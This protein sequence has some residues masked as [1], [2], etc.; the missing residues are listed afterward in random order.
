MGQSTHQLTQTAV[1]SLSESVHS[2]DNLLNIPEAASHIKMSARWLYRHYDI[3]PHIRIG[4]GRR[5]R[6]RFRR[7][8]LDEW[9]RQHRIVPSRPDCNVLDR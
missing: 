2:G 7:S 3:L 6:I 4:F 9:V 8:D 5:P 1:H